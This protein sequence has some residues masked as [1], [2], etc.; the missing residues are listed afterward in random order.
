MKISVI[1]LHYK[2]DD[3]D[4]EVLKE[5]LETIKADEI[6]IADEKTDHVTRKINT[7]IKKCTGDYIVICGN[8]NP[9]IKGSIRDLPIKGAVT[10]AQVESLEESFIMTMTCFPKEIVTAINFY[11]EDIMCTASDEDILKRLKIL[12]VPCIVNKNVV[13]SHRIGGRTTERIATFSETRLKDL[14]FYE[15]KYKNISNNA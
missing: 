5:T 15:Q 11:D 10:T 14:E 1:V 7:A 9:I 4:D 2:I 3:K 12:R 13:V 8:D 6:I